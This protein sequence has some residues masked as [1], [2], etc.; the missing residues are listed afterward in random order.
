MDTRDFGAAMKVGISKW[1]NNI[2]VHE[3]GHGRT[4][5]LRPL[6]PF[7]RHVRQRA[8]EIGD[9][10]VHTRPRRDGR[11]PFDPSEPE[12]DDVAEKRRAWQAAARLGDA[13]AM[14]RTAN[15]LLRA[16]EAAKARM[17]PE[18]AARVFPDDGRDPIS[19]I[20][21]PQ[22]GGQGG[23]ELHLPPRNR[24]PPSRLPAYGHK[25]GY[26]IDAAVDAAQS[27]AGV[28]P[29]QVIAED[30]AQRL[31]LESRE[32]V[33]KRRA[34]EE[35]ARSGDPDRM[36][37]AANDLIRAI[38]SETARLGPHEAERAFAEDEG[39]PTG[40]SPA[41]DHRRKDGDDLSNKGP[42]SRRS[43]DGHKVYAIDPITGAQR[44][45]PQ[46]EADGP[47]DHAATEDVVSPIDDVKHNAD[48]ERATSANAIRT[49]EPDSRGAHQHEQIEPWS[50]LEGGQPTR[51]LE[52]GGPQETVVG[53]HAELGP[54][55]PGE[56]V[57]RSLHD[58]P[59]GGV[60]LAAQRNGS[61]PSAAL[62]LEN[63]LSDPPVDRPC[64]HS[65]CR[66]RDWKLKQR[67]ARGGW[68]IQQVK[69][70]TS[71][72]DGSGP[73]NDVA[74]FYEAWYIPPGA[75][76]P[77]ERMR[78]GNGPHPNDSIGFDGRPGTRGDVTFTVSTRFYEGLVDR[79]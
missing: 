51:L 64:E 49:V 62:A 28:R 50:R 79:F 66:R 52:E 2:E 21:A 16:V 69:I 12:P 5:R 67:S 73:H 3:A 18:E 19:Q 71:W 59:G 1:L 76:T 53:S 38:E 32:I 45:L 4:I 63:V 70:E 60:E 27:D 7:D 40:K 55:P 17:G 36:T 10:G 23:R 47:T 68:V 54:R 29:W 20:F 77:T 75:D 74:Y 57:E 6:S 22:Q 31:P 11:S 46:S 72:I 14:T 78:I 56:L 25:A 58:G 13:G 43:D 61:I 42:P 26:R 37:R 65:F 44:E 15:E 24:R 48:Q 41:P 30:G 33:E 34:W 35:A 9:A 8:A 39:H